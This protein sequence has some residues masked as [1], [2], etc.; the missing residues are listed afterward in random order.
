MRKKPREQQVTGWRLVSMFVSIAGVPGPRV[1]LAPAAADG[2]HGNSNRALTWEE[3]ARP[4]AD[5]IST[6]ASLLSQQVLIVSRECGT[7]ITLSGDGQRNKSSFAEDRSPDFGTRDVLSKITGNKEIAPRLPAWKW[8]SLCYTNVVRD[9]R[10]ETFLRRGTRS[11][12]PL[13][14]S[15]LITLL[16]TSKPVDVFDRDSDNL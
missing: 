16:G 1:T 5:V 13:D 3:F 4:E 8:P 7:L 6:R 11:H 9:L 14:R 10:G 12:F 15:A 2:R